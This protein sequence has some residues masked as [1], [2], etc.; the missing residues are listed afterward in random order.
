MFAIGLYDHENGEITLIRDRI[1]EKPLYYG[2]VNGCFTFASDVGCFRE[3]DGFQNPVNQN[4]AG[5]QTNG[6]QNQ[7]ANR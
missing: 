4:P 2:F 1:G 6:R 7:D 3:L 5:G